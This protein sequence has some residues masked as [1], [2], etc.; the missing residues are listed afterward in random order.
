MTYQRRAQ[1]AAAASHQTPHHAFSFDTV[2]ICAVLTSAGAST[3]SRCT[4][5]STAHQI[6][7]AVCVASHAQPAPAMPHQPSASAVRTSREMDTAQ[8]IAAA[9]RYRL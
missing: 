9:V 1:K 4:A 5:R 6:A 7:P 3:T 2:L 8:Q